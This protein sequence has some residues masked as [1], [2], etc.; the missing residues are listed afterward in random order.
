[1]PFSLSKASHTEVYF[2][3]NSSSHVL[4]LKKYFA[5]SVVIPALFI[6]IAILV[7]PRV[8]FNNAANNNSSIG[9]ADSSAF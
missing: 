2:I 8:G 1:L 9:K 3:S 5:A 7:S 6:L 4:E